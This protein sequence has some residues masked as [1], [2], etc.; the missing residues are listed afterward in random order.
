MSLKIALMENNATGTK[1]ILIDSD[2]SPHRSEVLAAEAQAAIRGGHTAFRF[3]LAPGFLPSIG[4]LDRL[5]AV[6]AP[7]VREKQP[8][9]IT[10]SPAQ[11]ESLHRAGIHLIADLTVSAG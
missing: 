6:I 7:L 11:V 9:E 3:V 10:C 2:F 8:V 1:I 5:V 4:W